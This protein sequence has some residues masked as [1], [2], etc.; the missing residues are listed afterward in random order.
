MPPSCG[1]ATCKIGGRH[2]RARIHTHTFGAI[3]QKQSNQEKKKPERGPKEERVLKFC[4]FVKLV[5]VAPEMIP[6]E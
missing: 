6:K 2:T 1:H 3:S 5:E 4:E